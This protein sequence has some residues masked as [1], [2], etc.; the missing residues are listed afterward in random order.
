LGILQSASDGNS[1]ASRATFFCLLDVVPKENELFG[2]PEKQREK[3]RTL[4]AWGYEVGSNTMTGLDLSKASSADIAKELA[5]SQDRLEEYIGGSYSVSSRAVPDG[6]YPDSGAVLAQGQHQEIAYT[7]TAVVGLDPA[8]AS[9]P[10]STALDPLRIPR[11]Q[12]NAEEIK[13]ALKTFKDNPQLRY[14]SDGDPTTVSAPNDL[15]SVLGEPRDD[16]GRPLIRY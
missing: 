8:L 11:V 13:A 7:Y 12:G 10:F 6:R 4:V 5:E 9:S 3:L 1:W 14:I 2:Q 15:P 16:L